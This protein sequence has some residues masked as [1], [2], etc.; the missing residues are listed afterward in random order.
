MIAYPL[1]VDGVRTRVLEAGSGD[2]W[3]FLLHGVGARADRWRGNIDALAA[4]GHHVCAIDLPGHGFASKGPRLDHSAAGYA[5]FLGGVVE[6]LGVEAASL[7]GTSLGGLVCATYALEHA[8]AVRSLTLVGSLGLTPLGAEARATIATAIRDT[9]RAGVERKLQLLLHDPT[10]ID[11]E[12]IDEELRVNGSDEARAS[13]DALARYFAEH[14]DADVVLP[15]LAGAAF[16]RPVLVVWGE[17]DRI[18]PVSVGVAAC[19]ALS[20]ELVRIPRAGH[21]PYLER[22][23]DFNAALV[24]FLAR[25]VPSA[26]E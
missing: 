12:W 19:T 22:A 24:D 5:R 7:A 17:D 20:A 14:I 25:A 15:G 2:D 23:D 16:D 18:V 21:A 4:A 26:A 10:L 9:T 8:A 1:E 3:L 11:D 13:F 6:R